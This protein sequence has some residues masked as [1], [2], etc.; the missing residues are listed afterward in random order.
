MHVSASS[1]ELT[2]KTKTIELES[3]NTDST[4][5]DLHIGIGSGGRSSAVA[6]RHTYP[7]VDFAFPA[8]HR[9]MPLRVHN[10]ASCASEILSKTL[11]MLPVNGSICATGRPTVLFS[12]LD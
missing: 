5:S 9:E 3:K 6:R 4:V 2:S 7:P 8:Q 10:V 12:V 11:T 1:I